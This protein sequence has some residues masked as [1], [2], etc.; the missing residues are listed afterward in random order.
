M[1]YYFVHWKPK[2][3]IGVGEGGGGKGG[4]C[5]PTFDSGGG[6]GGAQPPTFG[7]AGILHMAINLS[8]PECTVIIITD[9][10]TSKLILSIVEFYV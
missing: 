2:P 1:G 8:S 7:K 6:G 4:S 10:H 3:F 5:P 9:G